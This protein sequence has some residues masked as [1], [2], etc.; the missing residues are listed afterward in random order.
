[1]RLVKTPVTRCIDQLGGHN[2]Y[3]RRLGGVPLLPI[4]EGVPEVACLQYVF[5]NAPVLEE[6]VDE[7]LPPE[8][9]PQCIGCMRHCEVTPRNDCGCCFCVICAQKIHWKIIEDKLDPDFCPSCSVEFY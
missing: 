2:N 6:R 5:R 1:M 7:Q 4:F 3:A 9:S 8:L